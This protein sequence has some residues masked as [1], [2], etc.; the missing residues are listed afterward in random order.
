MQ[1]NS[2]KLIGQ[3]EISHPVPRINPNPPEDLRTEGTGE[4]NTEDDFD[5][6]SPTGD[7]DGDGDEGFIL[8][9]SQ[10]VMF[11][12]ASKDGH[13]EE[14]LEAPI[15]RTSDLLSSYCRRFMIIAY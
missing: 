1:R 12:A 6:M 7:A 4:G 14:E 11:S 5:V 8:P 2:A 3:C 15:S 10:N 9:R 13:E